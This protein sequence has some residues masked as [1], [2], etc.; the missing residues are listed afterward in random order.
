MLEAVLFDL[1]GTLTHSDPLHFG[2]FAKMLAQRGIPIDDAFYRQ[3]I[4]GRTNRAILQDL[5]PEMDEGEI[6][7]FSEAKE[8]NF[9]Q[10]ARHQLRPM[11]G[12]LPLLRHLDQRQCP[13]AVVTNA[14]RPN[15]EFMLEVL[16]LG[17]RFAFVILGEDLPRAKPDPLP[18]QVAL[19]RLGIAPEAAVVFEDSPAGVRAAV[20]AQIPTI[21]VASSH[22]PARLKDC[23]AR[24]VIADFT[25]PQ[26]EQLGLLPLAA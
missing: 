21:G 2:V 1:D 6:A 9:R 7:D 4:S 18:Y 8:A 24:W 12:L 13:A 25:D 15:A 19:E 16:E 23:G 3:R 5:F 10:V 14:P 20:A 17:D 11:A 26:L 22:D